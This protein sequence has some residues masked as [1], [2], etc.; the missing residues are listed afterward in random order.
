M[1]FQ[2]A[3]ARFEHSESGTDAFKLLYKEAFELMRSD[4]ANAGLYFVIGTAAQSYVRQ[5][6]DQGVSGEFADYAKTVLQ[7]FNTRVLQALASDAATRLAMLGEV[8]VEYQWKVR[9]F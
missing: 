6:E 9:E 5:Y 4:S 1:N 3:A 2:E 7:N 8:A